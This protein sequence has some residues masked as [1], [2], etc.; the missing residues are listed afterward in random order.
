M[1]SG[2]QG[3]LFKDLEMQDTAETLW[4]QSEVD[5]THQTI[6]KSRSDC[7]HDYVMTITKMHNFQVPVSEKIDTLWTRLTQKKTKIVCLK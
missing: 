5:I 2:K 4:C 6:C 3:A 1:E 7:M